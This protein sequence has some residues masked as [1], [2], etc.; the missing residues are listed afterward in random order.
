MTIKERKLAL[1]SF[2]IL[3]FLVLSLVPYFVAIII[4]VNCHS[5]GKQNWF[6]PLRES[7]VVFLFFNSTVNSFFMALRIEDLKKSVT[8][9]L[10]LSHKGSEP[11]ADDSHPAKTSMRNTQLVLYDLSSGKP[12]CKTLLV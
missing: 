7:C 12:W 3:L 8:I 10:G 11:S 2:F 9:V 6:F 1:T 5:W 4:E